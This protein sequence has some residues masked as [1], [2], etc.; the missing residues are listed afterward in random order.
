MRRANGELSHHL[1]KDLVSLL[2]KGAHLVFNN[3]RVIPARVK[4]HLSTGAQIEIFLLEPSGS[5]PT[6]WECLARPAKKLKEGTRV[7]LAFGAYATVINKPVANP[8][9]SR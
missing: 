9:G 8:Y 2:P 5:D 4:G 7:A 1:V 3:S 6:I